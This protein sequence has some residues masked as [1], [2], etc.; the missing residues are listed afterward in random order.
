MTTKDNL[1][2]DRPEGFNLSNLMKK[3]DDEISNELLE[4]QVDTPD[5]DDET[6]LKSIGRH[7]CFYINDK[8]L[9][10][11]LA[12][13][14]EVGEL[15]TIQSLPFLPQWFE[16]ITNIRGEIVSVIN[17]SNFLHLSHKSP[18]KGQTL[19]VIQNDDLKTAVIVDGMIGTRMLYR[20]IG[21]KINNASNQSIA[22]D[23]SDGFAFFIGD[24]TE[25]ELEILHMD[26]LLFAFRI[27]HL[28]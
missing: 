11:P 21:S 24:E 13:V 25:Q 16:G 14:I 17:L 12:S 26:K 20:K 28:D 1:N 6:D 23:F 2:N 15:Q 18:M 4:Q 27:D 22:K 9:A 10:I 19:I 7:I 5:T 3:I 8:E